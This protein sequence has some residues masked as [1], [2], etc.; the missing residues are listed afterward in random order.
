MDY[1]RS[2]TKQTKMISAMNREGINDDNKTP[3]IMVSDL[4]TRDKDIKKV[5][6][7]ESKNAAEVELFYIDLI[8]LHEFGEIS[9]RFFDTLAQTEKLELFDLDVVQ[10]MIKF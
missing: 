3:E 10:R 5:L 1:M 2:L 9:N 8:Q 7:D 6:F 4:W